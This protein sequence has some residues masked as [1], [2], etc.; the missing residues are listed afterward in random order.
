MRKKIEEVTK[1]RKLKKMLIQAVTRTQMKMTVFDFLSFTWAHDQETHV[2]Q[3]DN[4]HMQGHLTNE[5][6]LKNSGGFR[7][8]R[9][10][11][12]QA[13]VGC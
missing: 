1:E 9:Q 4:R 3:R 8:R 6:L 11:K 10:S 12:M 5:P 13:E 2:W 7:L